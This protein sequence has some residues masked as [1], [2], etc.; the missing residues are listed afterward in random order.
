MAF[1]IPTFTTILQSMVD[2]V[3]SRTN[4]VDLTQTSDVLQVLAAV[5]RGIEKTYIAML[6]FLDIIDLSKARGNDLDEWGKRCNPN[7]V[8][9]GQATYAVSQVVFSRT[10]TTGLVTIAVGTQVKVPATAGGINLVYSTTIAGSIADGSSDSV[11]VDIRAA[12][13]GTDYNVDIGAINTFVNKPSGVDSVTNPAAI[14]NATDLETDDEFRT[15]IRAYIMSLPRSTV[16]A[17]EGALIGIY[18]SVSGKTARHV[19]VLEDDFNPGIVIVYVGDGAGTA[20][21]TADRAD[22]AVASP[23][24]TAAGGE[25]DIYL[26]DKPIK[27]TAT[28]NLYIDSGGGPVLIPAANYTVNYAHGHVKLTVAAYPAGLT[29]GD[30]VTA[31][32]TYYTGLIQKAQ[33]VV[34]GDPA[35]RT[36]YPGYRAAGILVSVLAPQVLAQTFVCNITV[37]SGFDQSVAATAVANIVSEYINSLSI[38]ED[39]IL[40]ELY[41]QVMGVTGLYDALITVPVENV[42]IG[43][44]QI[45]RISSSGIT[46]Y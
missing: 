43:I 21:T 25:V 46:V 35:D 13:K 9:R 42:T 14:S 40:A 6:K 33:K 8:T 2:R 4:L 30:I 12:E 19:A 1:Q 10:G 28:F 15:S 20:E 44:S 23:F 27:S 34:D 16:S 31:D 45:A 22:Y 29:A 11:P 32:Y 38:G 24:P 37:R 3:V 39:V 41:E 26:S 17:I 7:I 5:A 18:D 36:N